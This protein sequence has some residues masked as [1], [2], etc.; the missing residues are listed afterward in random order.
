MSKIKTTDISLVRSSRPL[1][2]FLGK[3]EQRSE[4]MEHTCPEC[5]GRGETI[6]RLA[7]KISNH[8]DVSWEKRYLEESEGGS[9][10]KAYIVR[11]MP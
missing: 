2:R 3:T 1:S 7:T 5:L 11:K 8:S 6:L 10:E 9:K 4:T